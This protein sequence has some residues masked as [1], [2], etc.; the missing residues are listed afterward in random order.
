MTALEV[1]DQVLA[2]VRQH[3]GKPLWEMHQRE[4][5]G[6]FQQAR[7]F[8]LEIHSQ[9]SEPEYQH[10]DL[11][12]PCRIIDEQWVVYTTD[13]W[14]EAMAEL[15]ARIATAQPDQRGRKPGRPSKDQTNEMNDL[16]ISAFVK[17]HQWEEG[18][19]DGLGHMTNWEPANG[20]TIARMARTNKTAV[21]RFLKSKFQEGGAKAYRRACRTQTIRACLANWQGCAGGRRHAPLLEND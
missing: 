11:G 18:G 7:S 5:E 10:W 6:L 20:P 13:A 19:S 9:R 2:F 15:R 16:I 14:E 1:I 17:H 12:V 8:N 21:S 3:H 4:I